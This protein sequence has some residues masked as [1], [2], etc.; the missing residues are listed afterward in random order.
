MARK[1]IVKKSTAQKKRLTS[2]ADGEIVLL[3]WVDYVGMARCRGVPLGAYRSR[4]D[5]GLGWAVA[6]QALTPFEDIANNPW[7][8]MTE[9]RQT[10]VPETETRIA[11]WDDA[12]AF[13]FTL[14][15][16]MLVT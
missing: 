8:P 13:H 3:T 12:P 1:A 15:D 5:Y 7:G 14:C 11:I 4:L 6:G 16:S 9:V 2:P 10:P